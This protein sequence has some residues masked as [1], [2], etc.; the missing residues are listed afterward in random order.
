M[1]RETATHYLTRKV[2][3]I[4]QDTVECNVSPRAETDWRAAER[5]VAEHFGWMIGRMIG[6][7]VEGD[8]AW[9]DCCPDWQL[10]DSVTFEDFDRQLGR[11]VW[12]NTQSERRYLPRPPYGD[13]TFQ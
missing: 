2:A 4:I 12:A 10:S 6:E 9:C 8:E 11:V 13:V 7:P 5:I 1:N 3:Q